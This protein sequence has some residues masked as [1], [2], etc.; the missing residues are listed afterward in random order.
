MI[1]VFHHHHQ[2]INVPTAG[3][4]AFLMDYLQG[5]RAIRPFGHLSDGRTLLNF[6]NRTPST[7]AAIEHL[8]FFVYQFKI[9]ILSL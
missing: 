2:P 7:L 3:A 4:Q 5:E 6:R 9:L 8:E 1:I